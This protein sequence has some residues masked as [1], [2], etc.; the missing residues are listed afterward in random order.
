MG[1]SR[2]QLPLEERKVKIAISLDRNINQ[3]L[4][5]KVFNKSKYIEDLI[6]K[7]LKKK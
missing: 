2:K 1:M 6:R 7:D 5:N 4:E 3:I